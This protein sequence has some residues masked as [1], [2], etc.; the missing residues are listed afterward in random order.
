MLVSVSNFRFLTTGA[1]YSAGS[2]TGNAWVNSSADFLDLTTGRKVGTRT[3]DTT[4]TAWEG[5]M[6]AMTE[7]QVRAISKQIIEDIKNAK[8]R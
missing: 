7:K 8:P 3:Y 6:S 1:R 5:V 4:S 2:M